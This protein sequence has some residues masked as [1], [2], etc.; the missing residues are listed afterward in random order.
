MVVL[1]P[2]DR[3]LLL[4]LHY[5]YVRDPVNSTGAGGGEPFWAVPGGGLQPGEWFENA[6]IRELREETGI[7]VPAVDRWLWLRDKHLQVRREDVFFRERYGFVRLA[8]PVNLTRAR[9]VGDEKEALL[10]MRWVSLN[11]LVRLDDPVSPPGLIDLLKPVLQ[12]IVPPHPLW[13]VC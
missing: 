6:A 4:H 3:V 9:L 11:D 7:G 2:H 10:D 12:G 5:P 1:D 13:T 8:T